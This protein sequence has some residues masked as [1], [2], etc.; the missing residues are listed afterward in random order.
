MQAKLSTGDRDLA[1]YIAEGGISYREVVRQSR[2]IVTLDGT[3]HRAR[4]VKQGLSI[5]LVEMREATLQRLLEGVAS[6]ANW[7]YSDQYGTIHT[8]SFYMTG[9]SCSART[10]R[11]GNTYLSG[12]SFEL[13][14]R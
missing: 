6:P 7:T 2:S 14:E 9:P 1:P 12:V 11:G 3:E 4:I 8:R 5:T 13:E 10:V